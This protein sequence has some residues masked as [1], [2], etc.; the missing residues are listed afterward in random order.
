MLLCH[1]TLINHMQTNFLLMQKYGY[2]LT[3]LDKM[4][5]FERQV[6][7][8]LLID[9]LNKQREENAI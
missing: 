5:P 2:T 1:E 6:Y 4:L 9:Y 8:L 3:E 7:I